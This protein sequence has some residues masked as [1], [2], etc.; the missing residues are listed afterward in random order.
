MQ[1][2]AALALAAIGIL[3]SG[4]S[5]KTETIRFNSLHLLERPSIAWKHLSIEGMKFDVPAIEVDLNCLIDRRSGALECDRAEGE[6]ADANYIVAAI[7]RTR[8]MRV[9]TTELKVDSS[10]AVRTIV[11]VTLSNRDRQPLQLRSAQRLTMG[12]VQWAATPTAADLA[13]VYPSDLLQ[14]GVTATVPLLCQIEADQ[15]VLCDAV[16]ASPSGDNASRDRSQKFSFA[17]KALMT[18]YIATPTLKSGAP[19]AGA[20][21]ATQVVF[22]P[23]D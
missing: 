9:D 22:K 18:R 7:R 14:Q 4:E 21:I 6:F 2:V 20:V 17:G 15:S 12:D 8:A 11:T 10:V 16:D 1:G 19:S 23:Q 3:A 5:L 13:A